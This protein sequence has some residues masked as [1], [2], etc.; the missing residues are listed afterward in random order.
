MAESRR[1]VALISDIHGNLISLEAVLAEIERQGV[2]EIVCLGDSAA[3]GPRPGECLDLLASVTDRVVMGN[4]DEWLLNPQLDPEADDFHRKVE[5]SDLWTIAQLSPA[6]RRFLRSFQ[7]SILLDTP[8]P[9]LAFHATPRSNREIV[10]PVTPTEDA[11]AIF[12]DY[13][14]PLL[15]GGHTHQPFVRRIHAQTFINPGSVGLP[16][17]IGR[18][19]QAHN[20]PWAEY[21]VVEWDERGGVEIQLHRVPV[22]SQAIYGAI[23]ASGMP[24]ADFWAAEWAKA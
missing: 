11:A 8:T 3:N 18:D 16:Y 1:R 9:L 15:A 19:G 22:E 17:V 5:E 20:P 2:E 14:A 13:P 23:L 12:A 24:Y 10:L 4:A 6:N 7:P 21:A